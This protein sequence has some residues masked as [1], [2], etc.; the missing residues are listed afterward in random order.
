MHYAHVID[1]IVVSVIKAEQNYID[2][3]RI[4]SEWIETSYNTRGG[5]HYITDTDT[6]SEDQSKAIR[7]NYAG[8]EFTYDE[9]LDA[10]IPPQPFSSWNLNSDTCLWEAPIEEPVNTE[11]IHHYWD[12]DLGEWVAESYSSYGA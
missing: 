11:N 6:P 12:E 3:L 1:G 4:P 5:V 8:K 2:T 9:T 7:K 10:F